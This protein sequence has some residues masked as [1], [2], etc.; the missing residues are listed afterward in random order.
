MIRCIYGYPKDFCCFSCLS[1]HVVLTRSFKLVSFFTFINVKTEQGAVVLFVAAKISTKTTAHS[2][3]PSQLT[4]PDVA[5][6]D[7]RSRL[8]D[9]IMT[10]SP[11]SDVQGRQ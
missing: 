8:D 7:V 5:R 3:N 6:N 2:T 4:T 9:V 11:P 10:T 1:Y